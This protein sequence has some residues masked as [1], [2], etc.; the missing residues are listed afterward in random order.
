MSK[1]NV[2][3]TVKE[4]RVKAGLLVEELSRKTN[5]PEIVLHSIEAEFA[6]A[7]ISHLRSLVEAL[8][9]S[10]EKLFPKA[11]KAWEK[12]LTKKTAEELYADV[13]TLKKIESLGLNISGRRFTLKLVLKN[14]ET[15]FHNVDYSTYRRLKNIMGDVTGYLNAEDSSFTTYSTEDQWI[16]LNVKEVVC[17]HFLFEPDFGA[18]MHDE[19]N[20]QE[21]EDDDE[22]GNILVYLTTGSEPLSFESD[23]DEVEQNIEED[24][25]GMEST[26]FQDIIADADF[27]YNECSPVVS[28]V[29]IDGEEVF[30]RS[31]Y[32]ALMSFPLE[33]A[34]P[35]INQAIFDDYCEAVDRE[36]AAEE[37]TETA[38]E[39]NE[40]NE[41][42][43]GT[44]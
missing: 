42:K 1:K 33:Y 28:F 32:I 41:N 39:S 31:E 18:M 43:T 7:R 29:D 6:P 19:D 2:L 16:L 12:Y 35:K 11:V 17:C 40:D 21:N 4:H 34:C 37:A 44:E 30:L 24:V 27:Y 3:N 38:D 36:E 15:F 14:G 26:Q 22:T 5:I 23:P 8:G 10:P 9:V 20:I 13:E 25:C